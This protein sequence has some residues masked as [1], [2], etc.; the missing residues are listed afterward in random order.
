MPWDL[1][2]M[3]TVKTYEGQYGRAGPR[4]GS[5]PGPLRS[6]RETAALRRY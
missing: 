6:D 4:E 5:S 3:D 2:L 1:W